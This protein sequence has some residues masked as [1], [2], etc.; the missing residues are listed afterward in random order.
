MTKDFYI[1]KRKTEW[2]FIHLKNIT[3]LAYYP[4][5][6]E[7]DWMKYWNETSFP[8]FDIMKD[9]YDVNKDPYAKDVPEKWIITLIEGEIKL[10]QKEYNDIKKWIEELER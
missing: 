1:L 4:K 3:C 7:R 9:D 2:R 5:H 10:T 8:T 6:K